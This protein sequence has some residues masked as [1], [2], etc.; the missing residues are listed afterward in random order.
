MKK[1]TEREMRKT[2]KLAFGKEFDDPNRKQF[3]LPIKIA[4]AVALHKLGAIK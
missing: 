4:Y 1:I 2:Y 3:P